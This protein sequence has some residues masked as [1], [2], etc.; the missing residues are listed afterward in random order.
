MDILSEV[1]VEIVCEAFHEY[2]TPSKLWVKKIIQFLTK[3]FKIPFSQL[4]NIL[5]QWPYSSDNP[6]D[7]RTQR[8]IK[9]LL[10]SIKSANVNKL[11]RQKK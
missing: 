10:K 6:T 5:N 7:I 3:E 4:N 9:D 8:K 11:S 2:Y 1:I